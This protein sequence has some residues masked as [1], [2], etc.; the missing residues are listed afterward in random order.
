[1]GGKPVAQKELENIILTNPAEE[2]ILKAGR[3][4]G[5]VTMREDG[6]LKVLEGR[7]GLEELEEVI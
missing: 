4:E 2:A 6:V 5:M 3:K 1:L 7:V